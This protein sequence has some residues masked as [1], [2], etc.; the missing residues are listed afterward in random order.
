MRVQ[1]PSPELLKIMLKN[2]LDKKSKMPEGTHYAILVFDTAQEYE[3]PWHRNQEGTY[4]TVPCV[5]YYYFTTKPE[6]EAAIKA[7]SLDSRGKEWKAIV[8][9]PAEVKT[10]I[11]VALPAGA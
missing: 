8:V 7:L 2:L 1:V 9:T 4:S 11:S 3:P 10:T 5:K 6:W